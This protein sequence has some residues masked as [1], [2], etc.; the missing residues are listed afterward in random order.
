[1]AVSI[2]TDLKNVLAQD[3][4]SEGSLTTTSLRL[5]GLGLER[6][7]LD[8]ADADPS[9]RLRVVVTDRGAVVVEVDRS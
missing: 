4:E 1:M 5:F 8:A 2:E 7:I 3:H 9:D 6:A